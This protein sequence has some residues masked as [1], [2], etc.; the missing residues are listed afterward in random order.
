LKTLDGRIVTIPNSTFA[1]SAVENVSWEPSRKVVLNI[2]LIYDTTPDQIE[3][4][5]SI[6]KSI[7]DNN[8]GTEDNTW[9]AFNAFGDFA[10]NICFIYYISKGADIGSVQ[11]EINL[12]IL[13]QFNENKLEM[14][15]PT[16]TL[17]N[18]NG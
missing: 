16:Q 3:K 11:T 1:D 13:R 5:M 12:A 7:S 4:A 2:G 14:A 15:F 9:I 10:L 18:I 6:L 17:Y 8:E